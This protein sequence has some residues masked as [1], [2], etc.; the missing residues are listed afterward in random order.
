MSTDEDRWYLS[1]SALPLSGIPPPCPLPIVSLPPGCI[2]EAPPRRHML[3]TNGA[4]PKH[5]DAVAAGSQVQYGRRSGC[6]ALG[7]AAL[8]ETSYS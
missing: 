4:A 7:W 5:L 2:V 8:I 3:L 6:T 1:L